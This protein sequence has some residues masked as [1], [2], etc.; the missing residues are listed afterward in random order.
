MPHARP[1]AE[2]PTRV[3]T[4]S[5]EFLRE[6]NSLGLTQESSLGVLRV[7]LRLENPTAASDPGLW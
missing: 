7:L 4:G 5:D 6:L 2:F 3:F 1:I